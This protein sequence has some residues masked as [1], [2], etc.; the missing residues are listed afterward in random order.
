MV[1]FSFLCPLEMTSN[2]ATFLAA[3]ARR[4]LVVLDEAPA[5]PLVRIVE[6]S[7]TYDP[8]QSTTDELIDDVATDVAERA[9]KTH[10][11]VEFFGIIAVSANRARME[12]HVHLRDDKP[13]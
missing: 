3:L 4:G 7:T 8:T 13:A 12:A 5:D 1:H 2:T 6:F 11:F 10:V 9:T